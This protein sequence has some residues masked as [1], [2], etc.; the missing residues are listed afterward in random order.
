MKRLIFIFDNTKCFGCMGCI[1]AC[2]RANGTS[3][4][5]PWRNLHK[6][7]PEDGMHDTLYL[8]L[9][10]NHCVDAPCV[11]ACPTGA[12]IRQDS[13]GAVIHH[14]DRC[15][16]CRYCQMA[17]PYDSI[18]WDEANKVVAKCHFCNDRVAAGKDPACVTTCFAGAL[19]YRIIENEDET[20]D[21]EKKVP[22]FT[23]H[24]EARPS[25]RFKTRGKD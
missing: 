18:R 19:T 13:D 21:L 14:A 23:H 10:C 8:S 24:S 7:P 12:M 6:L 2:S 1:A 11:R 4:D 9:A 20:S 25:I 22:G 5:S 16:G 15:V 3:P 17:C